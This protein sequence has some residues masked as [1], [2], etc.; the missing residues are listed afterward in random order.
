MRRRRPKI[1]SLPDEKDA[2]TA[3]LSRI[4]KNAD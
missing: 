3:K 2:V 4:N 1:A